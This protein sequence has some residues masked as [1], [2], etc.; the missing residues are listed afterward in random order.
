MHRHCRARAV[1]PHASH[2][3]PNRDFWEAGRPKQLRNQLILLVPV[4][5][6]EPATY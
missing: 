2:M 3:L 5:G 6:I 1:R 4:A